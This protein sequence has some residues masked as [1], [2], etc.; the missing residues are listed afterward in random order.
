[1]WNEIL[2]WIVGNPYLALG[3]GIAIAEAVTR[4][5]PT[6]KD[7]GF[8]QRLGELIKLVLDSLS[9]PNLEKKKIVKKKKK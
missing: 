6:K 3:A 9:L 4:L 1:M 8:V 2:A 7:D 5:T